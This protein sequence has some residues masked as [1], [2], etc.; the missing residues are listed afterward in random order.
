MAD[1]HTTDIT[2]STRLSA[3]ENRV[4]GLETRMTS[5]E[6]TASRGFAEL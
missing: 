1:T 5:L 4:A 2:I 3:L 6:Q